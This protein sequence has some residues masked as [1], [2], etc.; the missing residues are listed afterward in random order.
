MDVEPDMIS[1]LPGHIIDKILSLL[2][3]RDAV[4]MSILSSKWR[5]KWVTLP[6]LV[7]DNQCV[8]IS[9]QDQPL[10]KNK[11]VNIVD[12]VLLLHTGSIHKFRLSHRD[13]LGGSDIDR[14]ILYLSRT[15]IREFI[16]EIWKGQHYKLPSSLYSCQS[17]IHL[18]LF[19]ALLRPPAMFKGFMILKSLDLQHIIMAQDAFESLICSCPLLERLTL[20]NF[21]GFTHLN[22]HAPNLQ[23]F[24]T[25]GVFYDV[26]F[27][28]TFLLATVSIGLYV[29]IKSDK[30]LAE[31]NS[32]NLV[33]FFAHL[34]LIQRL[35]IQ[36]YFLKVKILLSLLMDICI[37][38]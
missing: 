31:G 15:P 9:S 8:T 33:K 25:G 6:C 30:N 18:E 38:H 5:F 22:I 11:L 23:F 27:K 16:L 32:S 36:S 7:F 28:N 37:P 13:F 2:S 20:M 1:N 24:D 12:H 4:R 10:V 14:W 26:N 17:L 3:I 19:N 21:D 35:E 34:P 29:D